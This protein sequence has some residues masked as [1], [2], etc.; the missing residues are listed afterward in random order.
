MLLKDELKTITQNMMRTG[1]FHDEGQAREVFMASL[2]A[3]RDRLTLKEAIHLASFLPKLLREK[4]L[5]DWDKDA[6]QGVSVNKSEF[7][8]E[9]SFHFDR[10]H[11]WSLEDLVP[12]AL[13]EVMKLMNAEEVSRVKHAIPFSMQDIFQSRIS[14]E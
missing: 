12:E 3:L 2:L 4:Y 14:M 9:V 11:D 5:A 7:L 8:A 10:D 1:L 6:R 13:H